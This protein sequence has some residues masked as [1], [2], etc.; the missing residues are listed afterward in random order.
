M[1]FIRTLLCL[2]EMFVP[3]HTLGLIHRFTPLPRDACH[4]K[5]ADHTRRES[6]FVGFPETTLLE[7]G[8]R[9]IFVSRLRFIDVH[10]VGFIAKLVFVIGIIA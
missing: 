8:F 7:I 9:L 4:V 10:I 6:L 1:V 2:L 3:G 5:T